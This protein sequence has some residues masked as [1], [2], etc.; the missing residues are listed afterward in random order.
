MYCPLD[1]LAQQMGIS[2]RTVRLVIKQFN[3]E[4]EG[5]AELINERGKGFF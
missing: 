2:A 3:K 4:L 1:Y 5:I